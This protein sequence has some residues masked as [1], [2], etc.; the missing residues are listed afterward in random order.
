MT[1]PCDVLHAPSSL[2]GGNVVYNYCSHGR[3]QISTVAKS[4]SKAQ[5][6][7]ARGLLTPLRI[8]DVPVTQDQRLYNEVLDAILD[9]RLNPGVKLKEDELS[10]IFA[11]SRTVVRRALLRLSHDRIVDIQPNRGATVIRPDPDKAREILSVRRLIEGAVIAE[12]TQAA[13]AESLKVL[14]RCVEDERDEVRRQHAGA[15]LRLSGDFH[16]RLA[17]MSGNATLMGYLK[18][19]VPQ[20]SLIISMY[21]T[22]HH[23]LCSHQEHFDIVEVMKRGDAKEARAIMDRHLQHIEDKLDLADARVPGDLYAAFAHVKGAEKA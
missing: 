15:G 16:I 6:G 9:R 2:F 10:D 21:Q 3:F 20:T 4:A 1:S 5:A 14:E 13:T 11:V 17:A 12:A 19:L 8:V 23:T 22:P 18:E 7:E